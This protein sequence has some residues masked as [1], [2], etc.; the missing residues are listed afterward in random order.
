MPPKADVGSVLNAF[1]YASRLDPPSATP[2]GL[3]CLTMTQVAA[4][5]GAPPGG[6]VLM[7]S[8]AASASAILLYESSL[9]CSCV[10]LTSEP[11][12]G[13]ASR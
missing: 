2:H 5:P 11:A 1:W 6:K 13:S 8:H 10:A 7:H 12:A 4:A 3:A 9:P